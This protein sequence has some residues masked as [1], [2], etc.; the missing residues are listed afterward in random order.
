MI[1]VMSAA[2]LD[3][4]SLTLSV[5]TTPC[6]TPA[7]AAW[8]GAQPLVLVVD[9]RLALEDVSVLD[10]GISNSIFLADR[11]LEIVAVG[12]LFR[13]VNL[14]GTVVNHAGAAFGISM[15]VCFVFSFTFFCPFFF[16]FSFCFVLFCL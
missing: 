16:P 3:L 11:P 14:N 5:R 8:E 13:N 15:Q 10:V 12:V 6:I 9:A 7:A 4:V 2:S 1:T